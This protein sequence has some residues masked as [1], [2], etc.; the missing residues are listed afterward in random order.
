M[1]RSCRREASARAEL[2][3][4]YSRTMPGDA[5]VSIPAALIGDAR[6]AAML[7][8]LLDGRSLPAS[9]LARIAGISPA[10]ASE[11][12]AK[13]TDGGLTTVTRSGRHRYFTLSGD[14]AARALE[15]LQALAPPQPVHSLRE[16]RAGATMSFARSC[17]DHLAGRLGVA[18]TDVL[19][20]RQVI[21]P[22]EAGAI[23][24]LLQPGHPVL[25]EL[26]VAAPEGSRRPIVRG[27]LDWTERRPHLAG[28]LGALVLD[29][30]KQ[31]AWVRP[32]PSNRALL[33]TD[34]GRAE[35]SRLL[36]VEPDELRASA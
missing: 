34:D 28:H 35:L 16:Q 8:A 11:H 23:G 14:R 32:A 29:A 12:L 30:L 2:S 25:A 27:C 22:L 15:A 18:L 5:D 31:R 1:T 20:D 4:T 7:L 21:A 10:T 13:L 33:L 3:P 17:Y 36:H 19:I 24:I 9:E 26:G 6:R